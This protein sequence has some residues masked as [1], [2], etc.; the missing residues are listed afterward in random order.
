MHFLK[1]F[2]LFLFSLGIF[3]YVVFKIE[4]PKD[5]ISASTFQIL[6]FFIP[7]TLTITFF[8]NLFINYLPRSF[9]L[10]L[11]F[12][13]LS[14][15]QSLRVLNILSGVIVIVIAILLFK[16]FPKTRM[17]HNLPGLNFFTKIPKLRLN[18][19]NNRSKLSKNRRG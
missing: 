3:L 17:P 7:L 14:A 11:S 12:L 18:N 8:V 5:W 10:G 19:K 6:V 15:L 1:K 9:I 16:L 13:V 2:L 4:P